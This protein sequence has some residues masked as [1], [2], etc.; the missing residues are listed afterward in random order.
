M[1]TTLVALFA[2][3]GPP[4]ATEAQLRKSLEVIATD[5]HEG[6]MTLSPGIMKTSQYFADGFQKLGLKPGGDDGTYFHHFEITAGQRP[7]ANNFLTIKGNDGKSMMLNLDTD[8]RPLAGSAMR[9]TSGD[10]V[11]VGFG[12][13]EDDWNDYLDTDVADKVVIALRGVPE[14]RRNA[15]NSVKARVAKEKGAAAILFVG[16]SAPGR[17]D[18]PTYSRLQGITASMDMVAGGVSEKY[19]KTLTGM[20][21]AEARSAKKPAS[22][23]LP[24]SARMVFETEVNAGKDRNVIG[25]L[26]GND[27]V[28]KD[29]YII[30]GGHHDHLGYADTGSRTG[31]DALHPGADDNGSGAVGVLALA[32]HFAKTK[33]NRRTII[34]QLYSAEEVGL[35][36]SDAW[37]RDNPEILAKTSAMLNMDMIGTVRR[38]NVYGY[39]TSSSAQWEEV[40][41]Q[42]KVDGLNVVWRPN[43]RGDSDQASFVRRNVPVIFWHTGLTNTYHSEADTIDTINFAGMVKVLEAVA[44][45]ARI[46]DSFNSKM[47]F[48]PSVERGNR[49]EDR[50]VPPPLLKAA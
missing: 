23:A 47:T 28:L 13:A 49:P 27:P 44:Q 48:N 32:Q 17:S 35:R 10:L 12:L 22:K 41:K 46:I 9:L 1:F 43:T 20:S 2:L 33:G 4:V 26:P 18:L 50:Q 42:L 25:I 37:C 36:G 39:G 6:R 24:F 29:E 8:F 40:G 19:F 45:T 5:A 11:Y 15:S 3:A 16:P 30:I 38:N 34:F 7:T 14:G 31:V 21:F